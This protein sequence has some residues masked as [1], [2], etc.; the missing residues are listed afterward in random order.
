MNIAK[1]RG[2]L[3][4]ALNRVVQDGERIIIEKRGKSIAALVPLEDLRRLEEIEDKADIKAAKKA[5]KEKER[6]SLEEYRKKHQL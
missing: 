5:L 6:I 1:T 3:T 4:E 2:S